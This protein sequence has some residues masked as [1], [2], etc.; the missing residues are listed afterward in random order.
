MT[1]AIPAD[2]KHQRFGKHYWDIDMDLTGVTETQYVKGTTD[3]NYSPDL[4]TLSFNGVR[5]N[6]TEKEALRVIMTLKEGLEARSKSYK[7]GL[8]LP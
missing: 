3:K 4:G 8:L 6:L 2:K 1:S 7:L 5:V